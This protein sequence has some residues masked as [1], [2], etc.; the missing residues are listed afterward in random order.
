[1][2]ESVSLRCKYCGAPFETSSLEKDSP[3][4][5]CTSCGTSQQRVDAKAY[6]EQM[7]TYVQSWISSAIPTGFNMSQA[8]NVDAVARHS[9]FVRN[10]QP[11][12]ESGLMEYK[13]NNNSLFAN[14]L[15]VLPFMNV[16]IPSPAKTSAQAFEFN[17]S[18]RSVSALAVD[19]NSTA[20]VNEAAV[21]SQIYALVLNNTKLLAEDK[22]GRYELMANN[23]NECVRIMKPMKGYEPVCERFECLTLLCSGL[24]DLLSGGLVNAGPKVSEGTIRLAKCKEM[25]IMSP[26]FGIMLQAVDQELSIANAVNNLINLITANPGI[27]PLQ[28]LDT[29]RKV[30]KQGVAAQGKW[31]T[32]LSNIY[33]YT[34]IFSSISS[35]F[36]AKTGESTLNVASGGGKYLMP[37]WEVDLEYSFQTG[38]LWAK[39]SVE[40]REVLFIPADFVC[41]VGFVNNPSYAITDIFAVRPEKSILAGLKG[42]ETSISSGEGLGNLAQSISK[43]SSGGRKIILPLSTSKE[44]SKLASEYIAQ[45]TAADTKLKLS[46]PRVRDVVYIPCDVEGNVTLPK[47]F[48]ALV[49]ARVKNTNGSALLYV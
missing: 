20:L 44:A 27:D 12:V 32:M 16:N 17:A 11:K 9:I 14:G 49:P 3:Y 10:I 38:S 25:V 4:V 26:S 2:D 30:S 1:M 15:L 43:G 7:M 35:V 18:V 28:T 36:S 8:A 22:E 46:K 23:F 42:S 21:V 48:G 39:K 37:F 33:R 6:L 29:I 40:V 31:A 41:D 34:E 47:E 19:D 45:R 13:F 24:A 5:T